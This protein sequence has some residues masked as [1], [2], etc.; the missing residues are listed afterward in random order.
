MYLGSV[1]A[2]V[3]GAL[4]LVAAEGKSTRLVY[5]V[6]GTQKSARWLASFLLVR[7]LT[8]PALK[9]TQTIA[10]GFPVAHCFAPFLLWHGRQ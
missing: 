6:G 1:Y 7:T 9:G 10:V 3:S 4:D 5:V 8:A 2:I